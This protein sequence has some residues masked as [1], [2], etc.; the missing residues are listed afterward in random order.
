MSIAHFYVIFPIFKL[1]V[2]YLPQ[3]FTYHLQINDLHILILKYF[4]IQLFPFHFPFP[5]FK[6]TSFHVPNLPL[7]NSCPFFL[8]YTHTY[9]RAPIH[10]LHE[11]TDPDAV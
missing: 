5:P 1:S 6:Y 4:E 2:D 7:S 8:C 10:T 3:N 11:I 9:A